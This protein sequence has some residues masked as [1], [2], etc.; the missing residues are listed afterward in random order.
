MNKDIR[1]II[2]EELARCKTDPV[3]FMKKYCMIQHPTRGK[4]NFHLYDFQEDTL[5]EINDNRFSVI[6][7][8]RQLGISTLMAGYALWSMLF[9]KDQNILVIATKQEVARNLVTKVRI[10]HDHLPSWLKKLASAVE[11]NKL[12]LAYSNGSRIKATSASSDA[13]RSE[14]LSFLIIDEAAFIK[15]IDEI[16]KAA[17]S[18]LSTG[19][20]CVA[21][22]TPNGVGNWF[23]QIW[24][25][26]ET[27]K[28][29]MWNRIRLKWDVHP[30]RDQKWRDEQ[31]DLLGPIGA[32]QECDCDFITSGHTL[33]EGT[34]LEWYRQTYESEPI[35]KR[36]FD[37][38][39][40]IWENPDYSKTYM[41]VAD[42]ARGDGQD[43]STFHVMD[44]ESCTQV[45]EYQGKIGTKEFGNMLVSVAY[46]WN[47][48]LLVIENANIGWAVIQPAIDRNYPNLFYSHK[49][50]LHVV[51]TQDQLQ[52]GLDLTR[53]DNMI[54]GFSTTPR[55][56]PLVISKLE[57]YF[58]S[59]DCI[60]KS[61]RLISELK[62]FIWENG[63][64]Q[65]RK[66]YNDDLVMA[67]GIGLWV[68]DT[69]LKL[70][71]QGMDLTKASLGNF[72][73][74]TPGVLSSRSSN[75]EAY[76]QWNMNTG[77]PQGDM[78]DIRW[79]VPK[80]K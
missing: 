41:V 6:L 43:Y 5:S 7:K 23:H 17:Q 64:A 9:H 72:Q 34:V 26:S 29:A 77:G 10:M 35:E 38:N 52:S 60:V 69:A 40:W 53:Q 32:S 15:D 70:R 16:W 1:K 71:Q 80:R 45:A 68:R 48:A 73:R 56:R 18:T 46:E 24:D 75:Q 49:K 30:D 51:N 42:T 36:G 62:V 59:R 78:E 8:S 37:G 47:D 28:N 2:T 3:H 54:P 11:D 67:W 61:G 27:G 39:Y 50:E 31:T 76:T 20:K 65:A 12:S 79:L 63:K 19:G 55:T 21:L 14:A 57:T 66:G 4:I 33:V 25:D 22:S 58:R 44:V 13:G 74:K